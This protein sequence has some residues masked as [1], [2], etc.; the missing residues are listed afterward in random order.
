MPMPSSSRR[1]THALFVCI[2]ASLAPTHVN[3]HTPSSDFF[4]F[5]WARVC[6]F[7]LFWIVVF[8]FFVRCAET[9]THP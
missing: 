7:F 8:M 4:F 2:E 5:A 6:F 9:R 3:N 1:P